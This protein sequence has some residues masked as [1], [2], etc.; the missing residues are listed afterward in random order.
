V[1][2]IMPIE[3]ELN[4]LLAYQEANRHLLSVWNRDFSMNRANLPANH[5]IQVVSVVGTVAICYI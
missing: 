2:I 3:R 4:S 5:D 1:L